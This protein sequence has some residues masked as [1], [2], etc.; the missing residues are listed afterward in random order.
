MQIKRIVVRRST[1]VSTMRGSLTA[2]ASVSYGDGAVVVV[3]RVLGVE[4]HAFAAEV[5]L[6]D[7]RF[8]GS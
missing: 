3:A 7:Y 1:H 4:C 6:V 2:S 8:T 5:L